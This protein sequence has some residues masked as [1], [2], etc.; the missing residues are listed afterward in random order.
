VPVIQVRE[1]QRR[2]FARW[3]C[4]QR[5]R[6]DNGIPWGTPG[7]LPSELSL[8]MAGLGVLMHWNDPYRPQQN[9]VVESTQGTSQRWV[10]PASCG[11]IE[12]L[13]RRIEHEDYIQRERYP[14]ING[15]S[16]R[17]AYP[18]L[19]HSGRGYCLGW[20]R[21]VWDLNESL[22]FLGRYRVRRKVSKRGQVSL[23]HRLVQVGADC[24]GAW[25]Y[26]QMAPQTLEWVI[27]DVEGKEL[28]RRPAPQFT[29]EAIVALN[30][31]RP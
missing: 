8:W 17:L 24:G 14:A 22:R 11:D 26:V 12:E 3:G 18:G 1:A 21:Q 15:M 5:E 20:E 27:S 30:V 9:G 10:D 23:Y 7:G 4:P 6:V 25:V 31:A 19:L 13:R 29:A 2:C 28:R 16:R